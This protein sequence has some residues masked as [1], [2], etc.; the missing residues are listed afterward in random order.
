MTPGK[1]S[2]HAKNLSEGKFNEHIGKFPYA[3]V[4]PPATPQ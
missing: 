3:A 2:A 1:H 4:A